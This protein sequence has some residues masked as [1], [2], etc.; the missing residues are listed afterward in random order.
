MCVVFFNN[1]FDQTNILINS[2]SNTNVGNALSDFIDSFSG[3]I[4]SIN[5]LSKCNFLAIHS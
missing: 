1:R 5:K 2:L 4:S 3:K